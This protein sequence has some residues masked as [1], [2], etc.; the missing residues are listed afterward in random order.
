DLR[1]VSFGSDSILLTKINSLGGFSWARSITSLGF[2]VLAKQTFDG[3]YIIAGDSGIMKLDPNGNLSG[4]PSVSSVVPT[5][6]DQIVTISPSSL[7]L[8]P[9]TLTVSD[10]PASVVSYPLSLISSCPF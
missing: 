8:S 2:H 5:V 4:C 1:S 6:S 10:Q 7:T 3:G 9:T